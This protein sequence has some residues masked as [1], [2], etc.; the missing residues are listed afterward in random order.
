MD[1]RWKCSRKKN[2]PRR[3]LYRCQPPTLSF[4]WRLHSS[5]EKMS[6]S[7]FQSQF[8]VIIN[9][10]PNKQNTCAFTKFMMIS[11]LDQNAPPFRLHQVTSAPPLLAPTIATM[12]IAT[13]ELRTLPSSSIAAVT[14]V[15]STWPA[16]WSRSLDLDVGSWPMKHFAL[17]KDVVVKVRCNYVNMF[18]E[19]CSSLKPLHLRCFSFSEPPWL[20][21]S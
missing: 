6:Q 4:R 12:T 14:G 10:N 3:P 5:R 1:K 8:L 15:T 20:L 9:A 17:Q 2:F 21:S 11:S 7:A 13:V 16:L 18:I 19:H